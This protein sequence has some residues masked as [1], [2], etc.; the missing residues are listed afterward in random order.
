M[1]RS[2]EKITVCLNALTEFSPCYGSRV[3]LIELA[4]ALALLHVVELKLL[5]G[6]GKTKC[7]PVDLRNHAIEVP[8]PV[9][10]SYWQIPFGPLVHWRAKRTSAKVWHLPNSLPI[11]TKPATTV[12]TIHDL[13][14][15]RCAKYGKWRTRYRHLVN[16]LAVRRADHVLT[17][18]ANSKQ[19]ILELLKIPPDRVTV[20]YPGVGHRFQSRRRGTRSHD[21]E[22][23]GIR[24]DFILAPGGL[25]P[26]KNLPGLLRAFAELRK[27]GVRHALVCTGHA[28]AQEQREL[29]DLIARLSLHGSV[30]IPGHVSEEDMPTLYNA[31]AAVAYLS[32]YEGFGLPVLEAMACGVPVVAS[33]RSSVPEAAGDAAILVDPEDTNAVASAL[34]EVLTDAQLRQVLVSA[35]FERARQFSW[36][37]TALKTLAVYI[38]ALNQK[39]APEAT[40]L[41]TAVSR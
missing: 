17:V 5:V 1:N 10:H 7:L 34:Y 2:G 32:L 30:V 36:N 39:H 9:R 19:D 13:A 4:R 15:L 11:L 37:E 29:A 16:Y 21:L 31:S 25:A 12:V 20:V 24:S 26:N 18:S 27:R 41:G 33:D 28:T 3:Y 23:Y 38:H 8:V 35:G 6:R 22:K 40:K 14:D